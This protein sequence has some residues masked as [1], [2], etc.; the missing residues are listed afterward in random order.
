MTSSK[1]TLEQ[2][3]ELLKIKPKDLQTKYIQLF[4]NANS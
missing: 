4:K 2:Y 1:I 3:D